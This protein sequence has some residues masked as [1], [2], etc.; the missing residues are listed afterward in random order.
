MSSDEAIEEKSLEEIVAELSKEARKHKQMRDEYQEKA[1]VLVDKRNNLQ[2]KARS[3]SSEANVWKERRDE[4]N[5]TAR[6]CRGKRDQ[7]NERVARMRASGGLGDIG[8]AR[9]QADNW[10]QKAE[11]ASRSSNAAHEKMHQLFE[12]A[13]K[14]RAE[15]TACQEQ[16]AVL[17]KAAD[18]EHTRYIET[19]RRIDRVKN[20][21]PDLRSGLQHGS[22]EQSLDDLPDHG[23]RDARLD[24]Y[25]DASQA[26]L[27]ELRHD[28]VVPDLLLGGAL[29]HLARPCAGEA[30]RAPSRR[31]VGLGVP[32][33][34]AMAAGID[35]G[36]PVPVVGPALGT[37]ERIAGAR[38]PLVAASQA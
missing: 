28:P 17:R 24:G 18:A 3:L 15:A 32:G 30:G 33:I 25:G 21:L 9:S 4:S 19:I 37:S 34:V 14:L 6:E 16:I 10:H 5:I 22:R 2:A 26:L 31:M 20:D 23:I 1:E 12:E 38:D 35:G 27:V 36:H 29:L 8:E 13:D 7:W 11:K